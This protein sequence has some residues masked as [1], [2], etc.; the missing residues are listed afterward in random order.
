MSALRRLL[1]IETLSI[2]GMVLAAA[3]VLHTSASRVTDL[4]IWWHIAAGRLMRSTHALLSVEPFSYVLAGKPYTARHEW[5]AQ[6]LLSLV[7]DWS[8]STGLILLRMALVLAALTPIVALAWRRAWLTAPLAVF[9]CLAIRFA[10]LDRPQLFSYALFSALL[11]L[12]LAWMGS[13]LPWRR[14]VIL[15]VLLQVLWAN[16][17]GGVSLLG[18][19][20]PGALLVQGLWDHVRAHGVAPRSLA[21]NARV[22]VPFLLLVLGF[23]ANL[24]TPNGFGNVLY[25]FQHL[26]ESATQYITEWQPHPPHIYLP[27]IGPFWM[28]AALTFWLFPARRTFT[29]TLAAPLGA[30]TLA[31]MRNEPFF[32]LAVAVLFADA[33]RAGGLRVPLE[34]AERLMWPAALFLGVLTL[35]LTFV[36]AR[37]LYLNVGRFGWTGWGTYE[38]VKGAAD[39]LDREKV[40]GKIF[41]TYEAGDYLLYRGKSVFI[42]GRPVDYGASFLKDY[43]ASATDAAVFHAFEK[44]YD[45]SVAVIYFGALDKMRPLPFAT[46]L[47]RDPSWA[48]V[49]L[50]EWSAVYVRRDAA[51]AD[52]IRRLAYRTLTP[53]LLLEPGTVLPKLPDGSLMTVDTELRRAEK[54]SPSSF[55]PKLAR[56]ALYALAGLNRPA[57]EILEEVR[58]QA[59]YVVETYSVYAAVRANQGRYAEAAALLEEAVRRA[60]GSSEAAVDYTLLAEYE[61]KAG[62]RTKAAYYRKLAH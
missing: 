13:R 34:K 41:N 3:F 15:S 57:E 36:S 58:E 26:S 1:R 31:A 38:P 33:V 32:V 50:D 25:A 39:V 43:F 21:G 30:L 61:T 62:N 6:I 48:L 23:A 45:F 9:A 24:L 17:H 40:T 49:Y 7:F 4:D 18:L 46:V 8:G 54:E 56:A 14:F 47:G 11:V 28:L 19:A 5:L 16:L 42:D 52:L 59:P 20:I 35:G 12:A 2:V 53:E 27:W 37:V 55:R 44:K 51:H 60:G 10:I 29:L 22:W